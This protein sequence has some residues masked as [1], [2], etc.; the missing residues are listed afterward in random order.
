[1]RHIFYPLVLALVLILGGI[2]YFDNQRPFLPD[3]FY[4]VVGAGYETIYRL[5]AS[6][7]AR[8]S[9]GTAGASLR[10]FVSAEHI[11]V[12][13]SLWDAIEGWWLADRAWDSRP[14]S[15]Q[16]PHRRLE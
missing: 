1:M 6:Q 8:A 7:L 13:G 11:C 12:H 14:R 4:C 5:D 15:I 2:I 16:T 9:S 10:P 3:E